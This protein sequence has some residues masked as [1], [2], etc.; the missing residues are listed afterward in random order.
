M[1]FTRKNTVLRKPSQ[2]AADVSRKNPYK[3]AAELFLWLLSVT[4]AAMLGIYIHTVCSGEIYLTAYVNGARLG[5]VRSVDDVNDAVRRLRTRFSPED[6]YDVAYST[7]YTFSAKKPENVS[8]LDADDCYISLYNYTGQNCTEAYALSL[9]GSRVA[10]L[11]SYADVCYVEERLKVGISQQL[12]SMDE[13]ITDVK[14]LENYSSERILCN[15]SRIETADAVYSRL[16]ASYM[17]SVP[18]ENRTTDSTSPSGQHKTE[19]AENGSRRI[20]SYTD[21]NTYYLGL[22]NDVTL[23]TGVPSATESTGSVGQML[24]GLNGTYKT[25]KNITETKIIPYQTETIESEDYYIG[26]VITETAGE[27]GVSESVYQVEYLNGEETARSLVSETI[28]SAPVTCVQ[29]VGIKEYPK[30]VATGTFAWPLVNP[31]VTSSFGWRQDPFTGES[32][33]HLGLDLYAPYGSPIYASDG[34]LVI[35]A[36]YN[37]SYGIYVLIDHGNGV[38]TRYAHMSQRLVEA[39]ERVYQGQE[40]GKVG[41]T[42]RATG[43]HCHFEIIIN[44]NVVQPLDYLP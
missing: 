17:I 37:D 22:K 15:R 25:F 23:L 8:V 18:D 14:L 11:G 39:G 20:A 4:A 13:S 21:E 34:G 32:R 10:C 19:T 44:G 41:M 31:G 1:R 29:I 36:T 5:V 6:V 27:T 35:E 24:S 9:N 28:V 3:I 42:G 30:P 2:P 26:T 40:I 7:A 43:Y 38:M 12:Q 16:L 33:F